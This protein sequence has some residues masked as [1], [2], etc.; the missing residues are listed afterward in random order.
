MGIAAGATGAV[1]LSCVSSSAPLLLLQGWS[2]Q[3]ILTSRGQEAHTEIQE[4]PAEYEEK[5]TDF[6]G[7]RALEQA[8]EGLWVLLPCQC[9]EPS[10]TALCNPVQGG[11][12]W[13]T[14]RDP[15]QPQLFWNEGTCRT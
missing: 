12:D 4:F 9:S 10:W 15:S 2:C 1:L 6:E 14:P 11:V 5:L 7:D 13:V 8:V 3:E